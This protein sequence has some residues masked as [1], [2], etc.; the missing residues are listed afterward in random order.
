MIDHIYIGT[1]KTGTDF[2]FCINGNENFFFFVS[3]QNQRDFRHVNV[4][5]NEL[6][7]FMTINDFQ[8]LIFFFLYIYRKSQNKIL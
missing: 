6:D 8:E 4:L 1:G 7:N 5:S 2:V 3:G